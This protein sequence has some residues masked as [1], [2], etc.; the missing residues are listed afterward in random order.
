MVAVSI[1]DTAS[2]AKTHKSHCILLDPQMRGAVILFCWQL[3]F[4]SRMNCG[5]GIAI[6]RSLIQA[7]IKATNGICDVKP[8]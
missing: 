6:A 8:A 5:A 2:A 7:D 1:D 4:L 3:T